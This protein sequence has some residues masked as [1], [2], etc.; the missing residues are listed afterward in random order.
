[1]FTLS[2][3]V[4]GIAVAAVLGFCLFRTVRQCFTDILIHP[5]G[6]GEYF[7]LFMLG[8]SLLIVWL[9]I[10]LYHTGA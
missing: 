1:M 8:V 5:G 3:V 10:Q 4:I 2:L 7:I 6:S 9:I